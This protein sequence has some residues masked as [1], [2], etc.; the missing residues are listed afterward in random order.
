MAGDKPHSHS[1]ILKTNL[2]EDYSHPSPLADHKTHAQCQSKDNLCSAEPPIFA[3][4][5]LIQD[6]IVS[7]FKDCNFTNNVPSKDGANSSAS[8]FQR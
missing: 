5:S 1:Q 6:E 3:P 7:M 4:D 2:Q 8:Q